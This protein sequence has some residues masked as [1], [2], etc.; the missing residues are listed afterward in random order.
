VLTPEVSA[1]VLA[2][3]EPDPPE[4]GFTDT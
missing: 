4:E 1:N 3:V 2:T